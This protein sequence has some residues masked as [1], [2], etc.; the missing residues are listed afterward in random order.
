[1]GKYKNLI[2]NTIL[3]SVSSFGSRVLVF[4]LPFFLLDY[5]PREDLGAFSAA[6]A[7]CNLILPMMH[8]CVN[9]AVIRFGLDP[10]AKRSDI[11]TTG[12]LTVLAGYL[13]FLAVFPLLGMVDGIGTM[14]SGYG[15][16]I[17]LYVIASA[18]RTVSTHFVR[19]S[20][21]VRV[22]ALDGIAHTVAFAVL[23]VVFV[24]GRGMSGHG[25]MLATVVS[26]GISAA[27]MFAALRFHRFFKIK[28]LNI[29]TAKKMLK[30][31]VPLVPTALFW[32]V[33]GSSNRFF[34]T[35]I[36]GEGDAGVFHLAN[37]I[38]SILTIVSAVFI[39][40]WQISAFTEYRGKEGLRFYSNIFKSYYS[41]VFLA[42]SGLIM[43]IKPFIGILPNQADYSE[44]WRYSVVLLLAMAFSCLV[45]FLGTIYN[46]MKKN[47]MLTIT[48]ALG[49]A[50]NIALNFL[51]IPRMG[52]LGAALATFL[53]YLSVFVVRAID[54]RKYMRIDM[55]PLRIAASL[56]ILLCQAL[57]SLYELKMWPLW[58]ALLFL[59]L[60][61]C[62]LG[63]VW[64]IAGQAVSTVMARRQRA[65]SA[66]D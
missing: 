60:L 11:F 32:W 63:Y 10:G 62:N 31:S 20:G 34:I 26:D 14:V 37:Q 50:V 44:A 39:S 16:L 13:I 57:V 4:I 33:T 24:V 47:A 52:P 9:E 18:V 23:A 17:R 2:S 25:Y 40:A 15:G 21:L 66:Q 8:L 43:L 5:I 45:T 48:T 7:F 28:G 41:L 53:A 65:R 59:A 46:A 51:L 36:C 3:F 49:G 22:F 58:S 55:Q 42:A 38:P 35:L 30:Y 12:I 19:A 56:A 27:V 64:F 1:M 29:Q 6:A 54:T 61:L